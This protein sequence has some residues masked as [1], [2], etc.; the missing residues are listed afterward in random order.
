MGKEMICSNCG[1]HGTPKTVTKGSILIEI[2]LWLCILLPGILYSLWRISSR[3]RA[4]RSCGS[5]SLVPL[6]SPVGRDLALK[7]PV[8]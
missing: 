1:A 4:C 5:Q 7:Y 2:V 6:N 3:V 8:R